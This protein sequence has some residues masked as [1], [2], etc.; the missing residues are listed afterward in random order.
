MAKRN[1]KVNEFGVEPRD[2]SLAQRRELFLKKKKEYANDWRVLQ[3]GIDD[4]LVPFNRLSLD[5]GLKL[6][7]IAGGGTVY[8]LHGDEGSGK[9]TLAC[10]MAMNYMQQTGEHVVYFDYERRLKGFYLRAMGINE[11]E[12]WIKRPDSIED[13]VK[14]AID[15]MN[16]GV[17]L[18]VWDSI[19]RMR[20][21]VPLEDIQ[22]G[23]AFKTQPGTHARAIQ[24]F[25]DIILPYIAAA[26]GTLIMVNQTR[27][28][29]EMT[30]MAALA[31][32][33]MSTVTNLN[34][35]LPG[36]RANRY[37]TSV[38]IENRLARAWKPG[39]C[40]DP[41]IFETETPG[42]RDGYLA[43]EIVHR[44]LKNTVS[45]TGYRQATSYIRPGRGMDENLSTRSYA[46]KFGLISNHGKRWF[47]GTSIDD[48]IKVWD[49]KAAAVHALV[50][51]ED[52]EVLGPLRVLVAQKFLDETTDSA[53]KLEVDNDVVRHLA[54]EDNED[55]FAPNDDLVL[56]IDVIPN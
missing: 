36:G 1:N 41:F 48:S 8:H 55:E 52:M 38:M 2:L 5:Y 43:L 4:A 51:E 13:G 34:Y 50:N 17:R 9:S 44:T 33:G 18:F 37:A 20:S 35:I 27:S 40:E 7:G 42:D 28:R 31:A 53:F 24:Q 3:P 32:K 56:P 22:S 19:P 54:G 11:D 30:Q 46:R 14:L 26:D 6:G 45:G 23:A 25:Y 47:A 16:N 12:M 39:K 21:K 29:I 49:N 15:F 10:D